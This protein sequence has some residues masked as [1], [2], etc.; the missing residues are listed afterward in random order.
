MWKE[1][2][3]RT[4]FGDAMKMGHFPMDKGLMDDSI[5]KFMQR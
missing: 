3:V 5:E 1:F 4:F 2:I